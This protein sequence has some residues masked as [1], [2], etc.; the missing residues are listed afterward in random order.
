MTAFTVYDTRSG[1]ILRSGDAPES[2]HPAQT[3]GA[4]EAVVAAPGDDVRQ[5]VEIDSVT[6]VDRAAM[7][8]SVSTSTGQAEITNL[9]DP[10]EILWGE[11][12]AEAAGGSATVTFDEPGTYELVLRAEPQYL[13][14]TLEVDIP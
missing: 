10:C 5:Y 9:P 11:Q 1:A 13:E 3:L 2:M 8:P 7:N 4:N 14:H 6:V 12:L